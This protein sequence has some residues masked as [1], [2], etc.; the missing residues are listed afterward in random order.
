MGQ[1]GEENLE[2]TKVLRFPLKSSNTE[3]QFEYFLDLENPDLFL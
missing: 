1:R 2:I 3:V